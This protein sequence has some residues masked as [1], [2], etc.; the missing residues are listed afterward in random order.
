MN[1]SGG[2][3]IQDIT[4]DTYGHLT[5]ITSANLDGR[6]YTESEADSRFVNASGDTM[7]GDLTVPNV[8]TSGNVDGRDISADGTKLDTIETNADV[9]DTANVTSAGALMTTG[10]TLTGDVSFGDNDKAI[11]GAGS[12]LQIYHNGGNSYIEDVG[13]GDLVIKAGNLRLQNSDGTAQY[14]LADDGGA[15]QLRYNGGTKLA[16]TSTGINVTGTVTADGLTVDGQ[17]V[18]GAGVVGSSNLTNL[19]SGTPPQLIA[20]WSVPAITWTPSSATE[21]V[22]TRDGNMQID[23]LAG[24]NNFSNINFSDP[25]DEDVGQISYDHSTDAMRFRTSGGE[26][27]RVTASGNVGIGKTNNST[28]RDVTDTVTATSYECGGSNLKG[29][30]ADASGGGS[31]EIFVERGQNV[32]T[33]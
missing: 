28:A 14:I 15:V 22:F 29:I 16:T 7:T 2:T 17:A 18:I 8:I 10:G 6:Y 4:L 30:A 12:D 21:A 25:D 3:V 26:R 23:I 13:T 20:G 24:A 33:D 31:D 5:G 32:T 1:N 9:T 11:F 27:L 19:T